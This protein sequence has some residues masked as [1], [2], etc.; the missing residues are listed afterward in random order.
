MKLGRFLAGIA[1]G[2]TFGVLFAPKKGKQLRKEVMQGKGDIKALGRAFKGA[3]EDAWEEIKK[4]SKHEQVEAFLQLSEDRIKEIA[5]NL[6]EGNSEMV[7]KAKTQLEKISAFALKKAAD[8]KSILNEEGETGEDGMMTKNS[9][10]K[11][12][13][14]KKKAANP[15]KAAPK[16]SANGGKN[17]PKTSKKT[18]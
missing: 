10:K 3:G 12:A 18:K 1:S 9:P 11:K 15:K 4:L 16:K 17:S 8:L 14:G 6:E 2:I 5:S 13:N 7:Q